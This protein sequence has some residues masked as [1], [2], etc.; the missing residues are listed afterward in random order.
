MHNNNNDTCKHSV[1]IVSPLV[2]LMRQQT[3]R[4]KLVLPRTSK[5]CPVEK[6][7]F[8]LVVH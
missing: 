6:K 7:D 5:R 1:I 8:R 2:R 3:V 4:R